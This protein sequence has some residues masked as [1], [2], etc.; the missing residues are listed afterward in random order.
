MVELRRN[1]FLFLLLLALISTF[2]AAYVGSRQHNH[3]F[4]YPHRL[5]Y[6]NLLIFSGFCWCLA[7]QAYVMWGAALLRRR[8]GYTVFSLFALVVAVVLLLPPVVLLNTGAVPDTLASWLMVAMG[9]VPG[10]L[11]LLL[12]SLAGHMRRWFGM[13]IQNR[14]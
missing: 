9:F 10:V 13:R 11:L 2:G 1:V 14:C 7:L 12:V 3:Q 8:I 6:A 4:Q 5:T